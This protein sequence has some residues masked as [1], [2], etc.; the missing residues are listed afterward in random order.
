MINYGRNEFT[1]HDHTPLAAR[2]VMFDG[3]EYTVGTLQRMI[4]SARAQ[5]EHEYANS[6]WHAIR[7]I[8]MSY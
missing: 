3:T 4:V 1:G 5:G 6:M 8:A 7:P 2:K